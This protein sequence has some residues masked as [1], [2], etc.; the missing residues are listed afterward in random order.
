MVSLVKDLW[1]WKAGKAGSIG[2][3]LVE[4]F[5]SHTCMCGSKNTMSISCAFCAVNYIHNNITT[6]L[7][8]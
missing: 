6:H 4:L 3:W 5:H 1:D 8:N 7:Q 2:V